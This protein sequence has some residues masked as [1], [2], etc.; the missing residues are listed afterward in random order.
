MCKRPHRCGEA[1]NFR[2]SEKK[3]QY[4]ISRKKKDYRN[5]IKET[6][7][8]LCRP[9]EFWKAVRKFRTNFN[10]AQLPINT[11]NAFYRNVYPLR[12]LVGLRYESHF[13]PELDSPILPPELFKILNKCKSGKA[14]SPDQ[15]S[16]EFSKCLPAGWCAYLLRMFNNVLALERVLRE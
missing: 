2:R 16:N 5:S 11:W 6:F 9:M 12:Q 13:V 14:P 8:N 1:R 4:T 15:V 7:A 10:N 3:N